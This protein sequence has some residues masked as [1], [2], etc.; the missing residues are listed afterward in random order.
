MANEVQTIP[1]INVIDEVLLNATFAYVT[2]VPDALV[3]VI[4]SGMQACLT[5]YFEF[6]NAKPDIVDVYMD[7][8]TLPM[9]PADR[10]SILSNLSNTKSSSRRDNR[11]AAKEEYNLFKNE[12]HQES[13][14]LYQDTFEQTI[15]YLNVMK[16]LLNSRVFMQEMGK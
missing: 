3:K 12:R 4:M 2:K 5:S 8:G 11:A 14:K 13:L 6:E 15:R 1:D 10:V 16:S 7:K 9:R